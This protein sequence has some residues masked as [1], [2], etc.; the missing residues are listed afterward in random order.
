VATLPERVDRAILWVTRVLA[1][2]GVTCVAAM[3]VLTVL[4]VVMRY[5]VGAP[6]AFTEDLAGLLLVCAVFLGMPYALATH[7]H[8]RVN[9][10][11]DRTRGRARRGLFVLGQ[12]IFLA[13]A[14]VFFRDA[15]ADLNL[16]M[17]LKL[18]TEVAR[19]PLVPFVA[20]MVAGIALSGLVGAWQML[21]PPLEGTV[22][23]DGPEKGF[24]R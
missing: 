8:I 17:M 16:T 18:K 1:G 21:R 12:I 15:L 10:L 6:F 14:A 11:Y 23:S 20:M 22:A 13:F 5:A 7:A 19:I 2:L 24:D 3:A 9:L 4:A